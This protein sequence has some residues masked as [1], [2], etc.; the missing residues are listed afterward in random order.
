MEQAEDLLQRPQIGHSDPILVVELVFTH[1][2]RR[3]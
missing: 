3:E 1:V 2:D